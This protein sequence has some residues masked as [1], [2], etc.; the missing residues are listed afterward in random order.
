[1]KN[2]RKNPIN[3]V[4]QQQKNDR[5]ARIIRLIIAIVLALFLW[6]Y[7]NGSSIDLVT[8]DVEKIPVRIT[9]QEQLAGRALALEGNKKYYVNIR[10]RGSEQN[11]RAV[12]VSEIRATVDVSDFKSAG[13]VSPEVVIQG[14]PN[15]V[16]LDSR[17]PENLALT[18]VGM[19]E[20]ERT[21]RVNTSGRPSGKLAVLSATTSGKVTA[22]GSSQNINRIAKLMATVNV[23]G[24]TADTDAYT[25]VTAYDEDGKVISGV[26]CRPDRVLTHVKVGVTKKVKVSTPTVTGTP[27]DDYSLKSVRVSPKTVTIGGT[28]DA[29]KNITSLSTGNLNISGATE[30]V[31]KRL[32]LDLPDGVMVLSSSDK[33]TATAEIEQKEKAN[34]RTSLTSRSSSK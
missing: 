1:M 27:A 22:V 5:N 10:L 20:K 11:L 21:V 25:H 17:R 6:V 16:I 9:G 2:N 8:Q 29:L 34:S 15:N 18:I 4:R 7:I 24:I 3:K 32:S 14:V 12:D 30:S 19:S 28:E 13:T 23:D 26:R 31:T 33:V